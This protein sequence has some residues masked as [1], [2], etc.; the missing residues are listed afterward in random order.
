MAFCSYLIDVCCTVACPTQHPKIKYL[1]CGL[2]MALRLLKRC[3][4]C[5]VACVCVSS[6]PFRYWFDTKLGSGEARSSL[7]RRVSLSKNTTDY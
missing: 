5:I 1:S 6:R 4:V 2:E 7:I 3:L